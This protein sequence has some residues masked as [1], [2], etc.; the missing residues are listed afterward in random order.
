[1]ADH[2]ESFWLM[3]V[4]HSKPFRCGLT[5]RHHPLQYADVYAGGFSMNL[6][7][8]GRIIL[9]RGWIA[10]LLAVLTAVAAFAFSQIMTPVYRATQTI[11]IVPSRSDFGL[12]QAAVQLLNN[13]RAYLDSDLI[14]Q[15]VIDS[16]Q[17]DYTAGYLRG[18]T[19]I[20][21]NRDN[22]TMQI[23]VDLPASTPD[24]AARLIAPIAA[25]WGQELIDYQNE[26]NQSAQQADRI[27]AQFQDNPRV[28]KRSP[29]IQ[30]NTAI[31]AIAGFF[32]GIVVIFVLEYLESNIIRY[33][34]DVERTAEIKVL[35]VVP[36][37]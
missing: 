18:Q 37:E 7:D 5:Y 21:A 19:T 32:L 13:R 10:I 28:S 14:A 4:G 3:G 24:E 30:I 15:V 17:L 33:R 9:R 20:N 25:A 22:L 34:E 29:N 35:A 2:L 16:L 27:R 6:I 26:L 23:D 1:M 31:G 11:L 36:V 12:T 8:Y